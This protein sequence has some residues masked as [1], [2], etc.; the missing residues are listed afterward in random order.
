MHLLLVGLNNTYNLG[1]PLLLT[2]THRE[3]EKNL[4]N[5]DVGIANIT[6]NFSLKDYQV[7]SPEH[8]KKQEKKSR[9][10]HLLSRATP[11]DRVYISAQK[12]LQWELGH[13][14]KDVLNLIVRGQT[15]LVLFGGG[16]MF[17]HSFILPMQQIIQK[18]EAEHIPV[19]FHSCGFGPIESRHLRQILEN[20]LASP[21]VSSVSVRDYPPKQEFDRLSE[22][23]RQKIHFSADMG[24]W[25][26]DVYPISTCRTAGLEG[27]SGKG[28]QS[29]GS[30][31]F[32]S[33]DISLPQGSQTP[34]GGRKQE[35]IGL[36]PVYTDSVSIPDEISFFTELIR[37]LN[38]KQITWKLFTNGHPADE[39]IARMILQNV[40][41][42]HDSRNS[43]GL[44]SNDFKN[45]G[46]LIPKTSQQLA[47]TVASF[48]SIISCRLHSHII[49][50]SFNI[51]S[52]AIVWDRKLRQFFQKSAVPDRC[53][54]FQDRPKDVL[55]ALEDA[56][57]TGWNQKRIL[58]MREKSLDLL[59]EQIQDVHCAF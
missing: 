57:Q 3:I 32:S 20:T 2:C 42:G 16:Q 51:P 58:E 5:V 8:L 40:A 14:L 22:A 48:D 39:R 54:T 15:D 19:I 27:I 31:S 13:G 46:L 59:L 28:I 43:S 25:A 12:D 33:Y 18:C 52:V 9:L 23:L 11:Y 45:R 7:P 4:P 53:F 44:K 17:M 34:S 35:V 24:L 29:K 56:E 38:Q 21:C 1:D 49:A 37:L 55:S 26:S 6:G 10:V 41:S 36:G 47:E 50:A 30:T